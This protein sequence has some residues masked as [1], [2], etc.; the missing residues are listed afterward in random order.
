M[1]VAEIRRENGEKGGE[2]ELTE[3]AFNQAESLLRDCIAAHPQCPIAYNNL[4]LVHIARWR[5]SHQTSHPRKKGCNNRRTPASHTKAVKVLDQALELA[6]NKLCVPFLEHNRRL[7][8]ELQ[9]LNHE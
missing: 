5:L 6:G 1:C 7:L 3:V 8:D 9:R 2:T 4:A